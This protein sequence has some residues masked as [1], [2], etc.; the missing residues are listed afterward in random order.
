MIV[1]RRAA[2][3]LIV[4]IATCVLVARSARPTDSHRKVA[5]ERGELRPRAPHLDVSGYSAIGEVV[6]PWRGDETL[7]DI[8][9]HWE[10]LGYK[11]VAIFDAQLADPK[12]PEIGDLRLLMSKVAFQ[13]YEGEA[14]QAYETLALLRSKVEGDQRSARVMLATV[15]F[16][17]GV[18][19]MRRGENDNCIACRGE[20]S[21]IVPISASAVHTNP[22]G[23]T[24]AVM[25]FKEYLDLF[26]DDLGV[27]WL[28]QVAH[29]TLG[30]TA[31][32]GDPRF[33]SA[34]DRFFHSE[35][36]IGA[37][38][39]VS[40]EAGLDRYNQAGGAIMDDFDNDGLLDVVVTC[41]N[42]TE[43]MAFY[44]NKGDGTFEDRSRQAGL[45]DQ[46]GG[47]V[48]YQADYNND[49]HLDVFISRGAWLDWP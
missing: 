14:K 22:T 37:F 42:P 38:R 19:A 34:L 3:G 5:L 21:C 28:L 27:R 15:I 32:D 7:R 4:L 13:L 39:N 20:S 41:Q 11:G 16:M 9:R 23:S 35:F 36:D 45:T 12:R 47:L 24:L 29:M 17:Q 8:A 2:V 30:E 46:L 43:A 10:G 6:R 40:H 18:T 25:H 44:R 33:R 26:P 49:G 31:D 1:S 48:C